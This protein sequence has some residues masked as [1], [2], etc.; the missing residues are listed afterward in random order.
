MRKLLITTATLATVLAS[1]AIAAPPRHH[2]VARDS[3]AAYSTDPNA[4]YY[5]RD[6]D[7]VIDGNRV[8]GRDPDIGIRSQLLKDDHVSDY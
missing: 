7:V 1:P 6:P 8:V 3:M 5:A 2:A 4:Q